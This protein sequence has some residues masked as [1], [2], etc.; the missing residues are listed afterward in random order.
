[1]GGGVNAAAGLT[2]G[3]KVQVLSLYGAAKAHEGTASVL[4]TLAYIAHY[5]EYGGLKTSGA[6]G[7]A[8]ERVPVEVWELVSRALQE[9]HA[10]LATAA[11]EE[12]E[13]SALSSILTSSL[14]SGRATQL[15]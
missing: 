6:L 1:M 15:I 8:V 12:L 7:D 10:D 13:T 3:T 4:S 14:A 9:A 2:F 11:I 5:K